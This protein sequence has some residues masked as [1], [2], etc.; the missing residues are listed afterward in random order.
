MTHAVDEIKTRAIKRKLV[1]TSVCLRPTEVYTLDEEL[2]RHPAHRLV[3]KRARESILEAGIVLTVRDKKGSP[4]SKAPVKR[5]NPSSTRHVTNGAACGLRRN[6]S[7]PARVTQSHPGCP[8]QQ[9]RLR[10]EP[11]QSPIRIK[12]WKR[13]LTGLHSDPWHS[14]A[15]DN[16][17]F[18]TMSTL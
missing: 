7:P 4:I 1:E 14:G 18:P 8:R 6:P 10:S 2:D 13:T 12:S 3:S 15:P 17:R 5:H 11:H 9:S 16:C